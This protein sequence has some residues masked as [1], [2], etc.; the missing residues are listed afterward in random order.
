MV[1]LEIKKIQS[2]VLPLIGGV[3]FMDF[4]AAIKKVKNIVF[5][6]FWTLFWTC[7]RRTGP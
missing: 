2:I 5:W 4:W 1:G 3:D 6:T 7:D